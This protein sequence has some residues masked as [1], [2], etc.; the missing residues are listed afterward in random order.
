MFCLPAK[1]DTSSVNTL[2]IK[3]HSSSH[4]LSGEVRDMSGENV[5]FV[6][7]PIAKSLNAFR[8]ETK[9][10]WTV[11]QENEAA[12]VD[13]YN[14]L[15]QDTSIHP[16]QCRRLNAL[17]GTIEEPVQE[18]CKILQD[19]AQLPESIVPHRY[20]LLATLQHMDEQMQA[21][22]PLTTNFHTVSKT[23][24]KRV[25]KIQQEIRR[26]LELLVQD[27][28]ITLAQTFALF[29]KAQFEEKKIR[30]YARICKS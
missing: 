8:L 1:E 28:S 7:Q 24:S 20:F 5:V 19:S 23:P 25:F 3:L 15:V 22:L 10:Y 9:P 26:K 29:D 16:R 12:L 6:T 17:V 14:V 4:L 21:L 27:C 30:H 2:H 13:T 11:L 18:L